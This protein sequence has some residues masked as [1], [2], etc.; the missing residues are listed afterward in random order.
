MM[1]SF[2]KSLWNR[3]F[4]NQA[5]RDPIAES[6]QQGLKIRTAHD[7]LIHCG[8]DPQ[9]N[10]WR[11]LT[12]VDS[13]VFNQLFLEPLHRYAEAIQLAPASESHHHSG[14]GGLLTHTID[15]ITIALKRR[16][17]FQ[18]PLGGTIKE[19]SDQKHLW[20]YGVFVAC[21]L[22]DIGKLSAN[23]RLLVKYNDGTERLW[24][25]HD[26]PLTKNPLAKSY[27]IE[28][29][30]TPYAYHHKVALTHFEFIPS[31]A[32]A[33]LMQNPVLISQLCAYLWGDRYESG[34]I[35]EIAEFA[36][37]ESTARN[38]QIPNEARFSGQIP[39]IDRYV[40]MMRQWIADSSNNG[41][42][43]N[44]VGGM[45]F[46]DSHGHLY[47]VCRSLAE[48]LIQGCL[49]L[50][51]KHLPQDHV[52]VYDILQEHGYALAT[53]DG[54]AIWNVRI[55]TADFD[56]T[57]TCLKFDARRF[58]PPSKPLTPFNGTLEVIATKS[59]APAIKDAGTERDDDDSATTHQPIADTVD[60]VYIEDSS[61]PENTHAETALDTHESVER[62]DYPTVPEDGHREDAAEIT[63]DTAMNHTTDSD[64]RSTSGGLDIESHDTPRRFLAWIKKGLIEKTILIN[65]TN[66]EVH[67]VEEGVFLVAP[68]IFKTF[69][70]KHGHPGETKHNNLS[71][72]F[73]RLRVHV[74]NGDLNI[75]TYWAGGSN[76]ITKISG[77][78]LPFNVI[79]E[80]DYPIPKPNKFIR[81]SA[82]MNND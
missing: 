59:S 36:D 71:R 9:M 53:P 31:T 48:K 64:P 67:I 29:H 77:W 28:F 37:R 11:P 30:S 78:L 5:V 41:I 81:K 2:A 34:V 35:G 17:G 19:I 12:G 47:L 16:R 15:V 18:L 42:K 74:R 22:H 50:G 54:K 7:L 70:N 4:H 46:V 52:R 61:E 82:D 55:A 3:L 33:W 27:R 38:L 32:R 8:I 39:V 57:F 25:P 66:A 80:N 13:Q 56:Y 68:A 69:L 1:G 58:S 21:L 49:S 63:T 73:A 76:R 20:T 75:H 26:K 65:D 6:I 10:E 60:I 44:V 51:L 40:R 24:T 43:I 79:Y 14:P 45:G 62:G 23:I 72:R